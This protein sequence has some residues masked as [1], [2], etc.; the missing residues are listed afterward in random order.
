M[1]CL[2][3]LLC[4]LFT[5]FSAAHAF[6]IAIGPGD[7]YQQP[8]SSALQ[9]T[10]LSMTGGQIV[11][12]SDGQRT[13]LLGG[14]FQ[15]SAGTVSTSMLL[16]NASST[17]ISGGVF[18]KHFEIDRSAADISGGLFNSTVSVDRVGDD[19]ELTIEGGVFN[20]PVD[21]DRYQGD[22]V[23]S[24]GVFRSS[25]YLWPSFTDGARPTLTFIGREW[26]FRGRALAYL[27]DV[28]DITGFSGMLSGR[29]VDGNSFSLFISSYNQPFRISVHVP[30]PAPLN[31]LLLSLASA[32]FT[33][34]RSLRS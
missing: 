33:R 8:T 11:D 21:I 15:I 30:E 9:V 28:A 16:D 24:G 3:P 5:A 29:L 12:R 23:I 34:F 13:W 1:K 31:L 27:N 2:A 10:N 26:T 32:C 19:Q 20:Q 4:Y 6:A 25:L 7:I 14:P 18:N 22:V 17:S